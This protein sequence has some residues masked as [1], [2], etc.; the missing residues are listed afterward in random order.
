[1]SQLSRGDGEAF[2]AAVQ[3]DTAQG[4]AGQGT[5]S[6]FL[7]RQ[8]KAVADESEAAVDFVEKQIGHLQESLEGRRAAAREAADELAGY[9]RR[10]SD[11]VDT[12]GGR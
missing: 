1:M 3:T 10:H 6:P 4:D 9:E 11:K 5:Y 12:E 7:H 2:D 8:L